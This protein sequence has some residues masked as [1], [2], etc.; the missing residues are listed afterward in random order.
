MAHSSVQPAERWSSG[1]SPPLGWGGRRWWSGGSSL[2]Q[3]G[4][5]PCQQARSACSSRTT[6]KRVRLPPWLEGAVVALGWLARLK[7]HG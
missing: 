6:P 5:V 2:R 1:T 4:Q 3:V 7:V